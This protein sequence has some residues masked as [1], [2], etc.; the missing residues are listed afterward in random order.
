MNIIVVSNIAGIAAALVGGLADRIGRANIVI[1]GIL[2]VS[3]LQ[4]VAIPNAN[5]SNLLFAEVAAVGLF[6]GTIL[7]ATPALV[8][9]FTPQLGRASAMGF[10]TLGPVAGVLTASLVTMHTIGATSMDWQREFIISGIVGLV[11][12]AISLGFLKELSPRL[13]DQLMVT[14]ADL[15]LIKARASHIDVKHLTE[16]PWRQILRLDVIAS[17]FA[18]CV[19]LIYFYTSSGFF[20]IYL[21]TAFHHGE[22][23]FTLPQV[24]GIDT[25]GWAADCI[26]LVIFGIASDLLRVRKPFMLIGAAG[27]A[28]M[29]VVLIEQTSHANTGYYTLAWILAIWLAFSA[30]AYATWMAGFTETVE[31]HNP[32]LVATGLAVWGGMLRLIAAATVFTIPF[33]VTSASTVVNNQA[34]APDVPKALAIEEKYGPLIKIVQQHQALF[35][36]LATYKSPSQIPPALLLK[37]I[38]DAGGVKNLLAINAIKPQLTFLQKVG[39]HLLALQ[40]ATNKSPIEWQHWLWV[41]FIGIIVFIPLTFLMKGRWSPA[42]ARRDEEE[43]N[44]YVQEELAKIAKERSLEQETS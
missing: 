26:G 27:T 23:F 40:Q 2:I 33:V 17:A 39:P 32:A 22:H 43:H 28:A 25:W 18:V 34:Y 3:L 19:F 38:H 13:R 4:S 15:A 5:S 36:R 24:N 31:A 1:W 16:H 35:D 12:W 44:R 37:A 41:A 10:W 6:E 29:T 9:D 42:R 14:E 11:L 30:M 7:V 21:S 20:V 8:R